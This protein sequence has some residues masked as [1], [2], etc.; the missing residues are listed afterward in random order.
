MKLSLL[1]VRTCEDGDSPA[2]IVDLSSRFL[3]GGYSRGVSCAVK[4]GGQL[5]EEGIRRGARGADPAEG[6]QRDSHRTRER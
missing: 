3:Q 2:V 6:L 5:H 4:H 1:C